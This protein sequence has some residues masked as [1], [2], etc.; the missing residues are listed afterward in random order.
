MRLTFLLRGHGSLNWKL[1]QLALAGSDLCHCGGIDDVE[2]VLKV[3]NTYG[4]L[5]AEFL[6]NIE[7]GSIDSVDWAQVTADEHF[8]GAL[9]EYADQVLV[10]RDSRS[11]RYRYA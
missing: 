9:S 6:I 4:D 3:C 8:Y 2:H 11:G 10:R 7:C 5:R 1:Q